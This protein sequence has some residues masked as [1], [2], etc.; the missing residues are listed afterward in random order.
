M[1]LEDIYIQ[2]TLQFKGFSDCNNPWILSM[3]FNADKT[4]D[5]LWSSRR[6]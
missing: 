6:I 3:D 5:I 4:K 2:S 1:E